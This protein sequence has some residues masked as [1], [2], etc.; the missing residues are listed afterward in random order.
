MTR[1]KSKGFIWA[2]I[3]VPVGFILMF[4]LGIAIAV[5]ESDVSFEIGILDETGN[6]YSS[7]AEIDDSRYLDVSGLSVDS[8]RTLV[9]NEELT[10]YVIITENHILN[11]EELELIYSGAGGINLL[12]LCPVRFRDVI[13][14]ER[15]RL[16]KVPEDVQQIFDSRIEVESR[17]LSSEGE[18]TEDDT[19]FLSFIGMLMG[20]IIFAAIFRYGGYIMRG[21]IEEKTNRIIEVITSS[22]KPIELLT[23]KMAGVG[24]LAATQLGIWNFIFCG[25]QLQAHCND[26]YAPAG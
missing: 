11:D 12:V 1:F 8:V 15:I 21:V 16:A 13:R 23:G 4:G 20:V 25:S 9:Q 26:V 22:V 7:L 19:E 10:G 18:E 17:R 24:A 6:I 3:L 5:W 14:R 2:T